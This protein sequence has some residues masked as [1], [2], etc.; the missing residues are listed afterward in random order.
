MAKWVF[1]LAGVSGVLMITPM[2]FLE[3]QIGRDQPPLVN[4]PEFYYGFV[5]VT[6]AWQLMF[7]VIAV[8]PIR[9]RSAM[10]PGLVEK[11]SFVGAICILFA[12]DRVPGAS[13][14]FASMD[15]TWFVLFALAYRRTRP[16]LQ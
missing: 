13:L 3:L 12:L 15:A 2:Y 6:L 8:D 4:H 1:L 16:S 5:G 10:L 14:V 9:Y 11:A 7:L